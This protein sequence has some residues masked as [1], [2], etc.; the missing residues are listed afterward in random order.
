M[1]IKVNELCYSYNLNTP[2]QIKALDRVSFQCEPGEVIGLI[3]PTG[4]G[5]SCLL[6]CLAGVLTPQAGYI[7]F[8]ATIE[9]YPFQTGLIIQEPEQQFFAATVFE[10][11]AYGL[12]VRGRTGTEVRLAVEK[13]LNWV[14]F[15]GDLNSS[16]FRLSGGQQRRVAIASILVLEP[17]LLLLDEPTVGLDRSGLAMIRD[18]ISRYRQQKGTVIIVS[19][20]LDFLYPLVDRFLVLVK[21]EL[22]ADFKQEDLPEFRKLLNDNGI[23]LPELVKLQQRKLPDDIRIYISLNLNRK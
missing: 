1:S 23:T 2:A 8:P 10:E 18:L 14:G 6:R 5:K 20:D 16:P 7:Q 13:V 9:G 15:R 22:R 3:G 17:S 12:T 21:G 19:H 11:V 4:S